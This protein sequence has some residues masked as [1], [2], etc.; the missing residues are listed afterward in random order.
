[1]ANVMDNT[2]QEMIA[3]NAISNRIVD[4]N[5]EFNPD[6]IY[7]LKYWLEKIVIIDEVNRIPMTKRKPITIRISS[8]GGH[9]YELW[10]IVSKIEELQDKGYTVN[11]IG[12]GKLMSCGF[13]LFL[14]G[15]NRL[16]QRYATPMYHSVATGTYGKVQDIRESLEETNRLNEMAKEYVLKKTKITRERLDEIDKCKIDWYMTPQEALDLGVATEII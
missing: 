3:R 14:A 15:N 6:S 9:C 2:I 1:M 5:D 13:M 16:V 8:Y 10:D 12:C 7:K 11:T 4:L